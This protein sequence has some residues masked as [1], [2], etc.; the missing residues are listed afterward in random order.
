VA[1]LE[2]LP[3]DILMSKPGL[4]QQMLVIA[5]YPNGTSRDVTREAAYTSNTPTVAEVTPDGNLT[6][7]RKGEA[8]TL[9]RYEGKFVTVNITILEER[10]GFEWAQL[11][12]YNFIDPLVDAKLKKLRIQPSAL[13]TDAEFLRRVSLI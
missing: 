7:V 5:H 4:S 11:P 10:P 13:T 9:V 8:A 1:K 3:S 2:V 12:Q 6:G